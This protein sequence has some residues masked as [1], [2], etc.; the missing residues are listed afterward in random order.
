MRAR[1]SHPAIDH[2][3]GT[4]VVAV[5]PGPELLVTDADGQVRQVVAD[6]LVLATG[7]VERFRPV[8]G[9]DLPGVHPLGG[10]QTLLKGSGVTPPEPVALA[11]R[12]PLLWLLAAQYAVL[13]VAL[14]VVIDAG[15]PTAA[16][17]W[18]ALRSR[19]DLVRQGLGFVVGVIR[20]RVPVAFATAVDAIQ[21]DSRGLVVDAGGRRWR[22]ATVGLA[23]GL[24][25]DLALAAQA[26]CALDRDPMLGGWVVRR[27]ACFATSVPGIH[28]IGEVAGIGGADLAWAEG[29]I[30][31]T[32]L[33]ARPPP[34]DA[35]RAWDRAD[36]FRRA[37]APWAADGDDVPDAP[38]AALGCVC[39]GVDLGRVRAAVAAGAADVATVK[40]A[41]RAGMGRC[42][43]RYCADTVAAIVHARTG[44][45]SP[46]STR[47]PIRPVSAAALAAMGEV[48]DGG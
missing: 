48:G 22:T 32:R 34:P 25:P 6:R 23:H 21:R 41:T 16:D 46:P 31:A 10:L 38:D 11:G 15:R 4:E 35:L 45:W 7:A 1:F 47:W 18:A 12:G 42:Q 13:G 20:R 39:E 36:R 37:L 19:G 24:R 26:G 27:D 40:L 2:R 5:L 14:S 43:G 28:A 9:G 8:L 33:A 30:L 17:W 3:P 29:L 44:R